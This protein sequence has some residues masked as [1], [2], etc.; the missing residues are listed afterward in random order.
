V[1]HTEQLLAI[2]LPFVWLGL[3]LGISMLETPLTFR[4]PGITLALGLGIGRLD[5]RALRIIEGDDAPHPRC[6]GS[7]SRSRP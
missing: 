6:T 7:T 3:R 2:A 4:S 5:T 1:T